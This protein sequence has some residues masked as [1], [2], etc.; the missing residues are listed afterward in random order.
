M[1]ALQDQRPTSDSLK[2][3]TR[4]ENQKEVIRKRS[5][6]AQVI[7]WTTGLPPRTQG[8]CRNKQKHND[9]TMRKQQQL[10]ENHLQKLYHG[11]KK[12][13]DAQIMGT[14][15][16]QTQRLRKSLVVTQTYDMRANT[17]NHT[18]KPREHHVSLSTNPTHGERN[19]IK[20]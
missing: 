4:C 18:A 10:H 7:T 17:H 13:E 5:K 2:D 6:S 14:C 3:Y 15:N 19:T 12:E 11:N 20:K 1:T 9:E 16:T 8:G